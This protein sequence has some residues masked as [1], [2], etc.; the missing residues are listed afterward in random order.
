M[1]NCEKQ[2]V[3][4][5]NQL[6]GEISQYINEAIFINNRS[7]DN[8]EKAI[9]EKLTSLNLNFPVKVLRNNENYGLGGSHKVAF[10]YAINH[11]F[12]YVI[13]LH[14]DDQ[15]SVSDF[16][17]VLKE[18]IFRH[19]DCCLGARFMKESKLPGYSKFRILGNKV[20]NILFSIAIG[21]KI[22][23]LGAGL[24]MYSTKMLSSK[25]YMLFPDN[26][27]FNCYMC[28]ALAAFMQNHLYIPI[29]WR[30]EDQI[31]NV[32]MTRQ[33]IQTLKMAINYFFKR[34]LF[35]QK[36]ARSNKFEK[37]DSEVVYSKEISK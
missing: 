24:N 23:D 4:V 37:Y 20:F 35:L 14:G 1:Y 28:F 34:Q 32:K 10:N 25:Y 5:A 30:E 16:I 33:A 17:P 36:D 15:G 13:V 9:V 2:I 22:F 29:T 18:G 31:S 11:G 3:R 7:T 27:T 6:T 21:K 8:G 26:L 12:D 19:Y